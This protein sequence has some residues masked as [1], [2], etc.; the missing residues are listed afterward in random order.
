MHKI[1]KLCG[2]PS[3]DYWQKSRLPHATSFK[4]Q[5]RYRR[6]V[7]DTFKDFT[8]A[9]LALVDKL[10]SIEP[11]NRGSAASALRSE[12]TLSS[13]LFINSSFMICCNYGYIFIIWTFP[14]QFFTTK[15]LPCDPS[16]L[17]K[18]P[19]CKE[20]DAKLRDEEARRYDI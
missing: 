16:S 18:Y 13:P 5:H 11:E 20:I 2:S 4:P 12:V 14:F 17:P 8:P 6:C 1:F 9:A 7:P 19:P 15:P 10:L 3:E